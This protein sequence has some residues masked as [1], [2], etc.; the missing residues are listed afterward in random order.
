LVTLPGSER[1][2]Q[3]SGFQKVHEAREVTLYR[4]DLPQGKEP[5]SDWSVG[6][7]E[8]PRTLIPILTEFGE[9]LRLIGYSWDPPTVKPGEPVTLSLLWEC[10]RPPS[11]DWSISVRARAG[12]D[13][14]PDRKIQS[15]DHFPFGGTFRMVDW[16]PGETYLDRWTV[17]LEKKFPEGPSTFDVRL[18]RLARFGSHVKDIPF[19]E[20]ESLTP[21]G[22]DDPIT[23]I[24]YGP[25]V[26]GDGKSED[27]ERGENNVPI[28]AEID[29]EEG[30]RWS[31][32]RIDLMNRTTLYWEGTR[33]RPPPRDFSVTYVD[34]TTGNGYRQ[35]VPCRLFGRPPSTLGESERAGYLLPGAVASMVQGREFSL[36]L[37]TV[38]PKTGEEIESYTLSVT[39]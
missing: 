16:N 18:Q 26:R 30:G 27:L 14:M 24:G 11:V 1:P 3:G 32:I 15:F 17:E 5:L 6:D 8:D 35:V 7:G 37:G 12:I 36:I 20:W 39:K 25:E 29:F 10:E 19:Y 33:K 2:T 38:D 31:G 28:K 34:P 13:E 9:G 4:S 21:E 22:S 23:F